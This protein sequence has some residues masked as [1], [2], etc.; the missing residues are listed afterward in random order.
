MFRR[1]L[2]AACSIAGVLMGTVPAFAQTAQPSLAEIAKQEAERRKALGKASKVYTNDDTRGGRPLTT[3]AATAPKAAVQAEKAAAGR[4]EQADAAAL[5]DDQAKAALEALQ[6]KIADLKA[7]IAE[8][9]QG[10]QK[11]QQQVD[12]LNNAVINSFDETVREGLV[13]DREQL[14]AGY[15]KQEV[16]NEAMRMLLAEAEAAVRKLQTGSR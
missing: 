12:Q 5:R 9:E 11:I 13:K 1:R 16:D 14:L 6:K 10:Q 7:R 15:R 2:V 8:G 3:G 4:E